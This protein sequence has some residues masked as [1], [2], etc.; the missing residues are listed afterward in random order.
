MKAQHNHGR[1]AMAQPAGIAMGNSVLLWRNTDG[2][3]VPYCPVLCRDVG[4]NQT[5]D[6]RTRSLS[7]ALMR[8]SFLPWCWHAVDI[9][10]V[11]CIAASHG[12]AC[13]LHRVRGSDGCAGSNK[14]RAFIGS[15]NLV[16]ATLLQQLLGQAAI[17]MLL[18]G[19]MFPT[20]CSVGKCALL[21]S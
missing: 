18:L 2:R 6:Q 12:V 21:R 17:R 3:W 9:C 11:A 15:T 13:V 5:N 19:V 20:C 8:V 1:Q 16:A 14:G 7:I 4:T 10:V